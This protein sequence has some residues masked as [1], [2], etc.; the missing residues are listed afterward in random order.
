[1]ASKRKLVVIGNGMAGARCVE[2]ILA[3][4]GADQF[5]ITMFGDEPYGNYNR[6]LLSDV[7]NGSHDASEIFLNSLPWYEENGIHLHAG[8]RAERI[9][10]HA[11]EVIGTGG[12]K[13][14][15]DE[16]I[17][18]TGSLPFI[19]PMAGLKLADG[20]D[21]PG[22]FVF[23]N[24]DDC[25]R[26]TAYAMG[27]KS[28]VVIGGGL[29]GLEAAR[30]LQNFALAVHVI[31]RGDG[32]MNQQ[33]DGSAAS[34]LKKTLEQLGITIHLRK[35]TRLVLGDDCV[36]GIEFADGKRIDC[37]LVVVAAG[38]KPNVELAVHSGIAVERGIVVDNQ[39]RTD[40]PNVYAVGE[41]VQHRGQVYGLVAPLWEQAKVLADHLTGI[42]PEAAYHGSKIATKLKVMGV[43]VASMGVKAPEHEDD[44][45]VQY[46]EPRHGVYKTIVIRD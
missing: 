2:E 15:Y 24:L 30:G 29:L 14:R 4:G 44:E 21:K 26:I 22:V 32:I 41:C 18:A 42:N 3:R 1:M 7:L 19:P 23:R 46:S 11:R 17:L 37:D 36:T 9:Y 27:K 20:S 38:I 16:L 5:E 34:I 35:D 8:V 6:I 31:Q 12:V 40:A 10:R 28:A 39:L 13:E 25:K 33:L 45:F 43:E